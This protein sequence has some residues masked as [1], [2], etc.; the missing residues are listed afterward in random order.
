MGA[1]VVVEGHHDHGLTTGEN[2][3]GIG[4]ALGIALQPSHVAVLSFLDPFLISVGMRS[5]H[6]RGHLEVCEAE[7]AGLFGEKG[8]EFGGVDKGTLT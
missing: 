3:A 1:G 6:G 7:F 8:F 5:P 2:N 4:T